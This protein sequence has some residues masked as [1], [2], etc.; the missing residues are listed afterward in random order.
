MLHAEQDSLQ[1]LIN[2]CKAND[3]KSQQALYNSYS[4]KMFAICL[5]YAQDEMEAEDILM[6]GF[7]RVFTKIDSYGGNG[8]FEGWMRSIIINTALNVYRKNIRSVKTTTME[9]H[10]KY[11]HYDVQHHNHDLKYLLNLLH[12]LPEYYRTAFNMFVIEGYSHKEIG[13]TLGIT[14]AL[15]KTHVMRARKML[16]Q[17]I[18]NAGLKVKY[19]LANAS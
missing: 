12:S 3:R 17:K 7:T 11:L 8:S 9:D 10:C 18:E 16:Q 19:R 4:S 5:R 6:I 13:Q 2:G 1:Q 14:E 15:S